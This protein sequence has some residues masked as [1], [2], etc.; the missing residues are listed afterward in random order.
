MGH[1]RRPMRW[2]AK[3]AS[4]T[5]SKGSIGDAGRAIID[6]RSVNTKVALRTPGLRQDGP[7]ELNASQ[8][9][10]SE[11]RCSPSDL[12]LRDAVGKLQELLSTRVRYLLG[13]N[14][15]TTTNETSSRS[16]AHGRWQQKEF[17]ES[18]ASDRVLPPQLAYGGQRTP[19]RPVRHTPAPSPGYATS[20]SL[21][22]GVHSL[23][24]SAE[25]ACR[26]I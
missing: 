15:S 25:G 14:I 11:L 3:A 26:D 20:S 18:R 5:P 6:S 13:D 23:L 1:S 9:L 19:R 16:A 12:T 4:A 22:G 17:R 8:S 7:P 24:E 10:H 2:R 21:T